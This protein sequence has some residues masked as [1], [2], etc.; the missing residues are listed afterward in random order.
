MP[1]ALGLADV[2]AVVLH[3]AAWIGV[4]WL[5][6][7]PQGGRVSVAVLMEEHRR[8]WMREF[9]TR[10]PRIMDG[11]LLGMLSQSASF[12]ASATMIAIGGG[13]ALIGN[14]ETVARAAEEVVPGLLP[15]LVWQIKLALALLLVVNA[16]LR[17]VWAHRLFGYCAVLMGAVPNDASHPEAMGLAMKA[18]EINIHAA[19]NFN[20]GLRAV[21]FAIGA[22]AWLAG[23]LALTLATA[24]VLWTTWRREF[25]SGSRRALLRR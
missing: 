25:A 11:A 13:L 24:A 19:R 22:L 15:E 21:Y 18:A 16:F 12:F 1:A 2:A 14:P 9:L 23:P 5:V 10:Q 3:L 20:A 6:A 17:F 8:N 7:N 4:G